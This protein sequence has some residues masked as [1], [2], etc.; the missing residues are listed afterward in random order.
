LDK[1]KKGDIAMLVTDF[2]NDLD[3]R[4]LG[5]FL[6][7]RKKRQ[8]SPAVE[9]RI[10]NLSDRMKDLVDPRVNFRLLAVDRVNPGKIRLQNGTAFESPK[11]AQT[12][13]DARV[14]CAFIAT[15]GPALEKETD[16]LMENDHYAD[17][18]VLDVMASLAVEDV[19]EQ[20]H[21]RMARR[22]RRKGQSVTLR[23]SP[24]Y[25]DWPLKEQQT[26]FGQFKKTESLHVELSD[27][28]LMSPRK[29]V[30]GVFGVVDSPS[31]R[32]FAGYNPCHHCSK[33][34][35]IARR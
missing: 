21:R 23:F 3:E 27:T 12:L 20:F 25:C 7:L 1:I 17:A 2:Q 32:P 24:G 30:S 15:I 16:R 26:L 29:S 4:R 18:Y 34:D 8:M 13:K 19:V 9:R 10:D 22:L 5:R 14:A 35:C 11:L 31:D 6:G 28:F 33:T